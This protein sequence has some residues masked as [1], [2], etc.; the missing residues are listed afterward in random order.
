MI[1]AKVFAPETVTPPVP[2]ILKAGYDAPPPWNV[3][4]VDDAILI[5]PV[6]LVVKFVVVFIAQTVPPLL[7]VI[8]P[9]EPKLI[10]RVFE[11]LEEKKDKPDNVLQGLLSGEWE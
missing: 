11:L 6:P 1:L 2:S 5:V 8:L 9:L 4:S 3:L 10:E 7:K